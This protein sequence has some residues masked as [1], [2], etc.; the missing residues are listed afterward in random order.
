MVDKKEIQLTSG[1][2]ILFYG[3]L[4]TIGFALIAPVLAVAASGA[5][6]MLKLA[7]CVGI[8]FMIWLARPWFVIKWKNI[9]L[10]LLKAEARANPIET[11]QNEL[12]ERKQSVVEARQ[13][14]VKLQSMR[15][16]LKQQVAEFEREYGSPDKNLVTMLSGLSSLVDQL[17]TRLEVARK[18]LVEF[19]QHIK[20]QA[21][22]YKIAINTGE[23]ARELRQADGNNDPMRQFLH[24]EAI[25]SVRVTFNDAMAGVN[26]LLSDSSVITQINEDKEIEGII[27]VTPID[28]VSLV[29]DKLNKE[30]MSV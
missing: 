2:K 30:V 28:P 3:G 1:Q 6:S 4:I 17:E 20:R 14:F 8:I 5:M 16:T 26:Q 23:L 22:Q 29:E 25:E 11:L 19:E 21:A 15:V 24:D 12:I 13:R 7:V 27:D 18:G 9:V 10:K